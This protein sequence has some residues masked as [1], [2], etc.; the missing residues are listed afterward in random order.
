VPSLKKILFLQ[1]TC[2]TEENMKAKFKSLVEKL[3][4]SYWFIPSTMAVSAIVASQL[5]LYL[6]QALG[7]AW[8]G[9]QANF[10]TTGIEGA[11]S[12]LATIAS[13]MMTVTGVVISITIVSLSLAAQQFGPRLLQHFMRDRGNQFVLGTVTSTFLYCLLVLRTIGTA[14]GDAFIPHASV[15]MSVLLGVMNVGVL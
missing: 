7:P 14:A 15:L 11:R 1:I 9:S 4:S 3:L 2:R 5:L 8:L 13:S 6:D 12:M 10:F